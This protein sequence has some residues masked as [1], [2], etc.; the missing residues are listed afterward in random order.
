MLRLITAASAI[1][2][3]AP[4]IAQDASPSADEVQPEV[5]APAEAPE[6]APAPATPSREEAVKQLVESEFA[7]YDEDQSGELSKEEFAKWVSALRSK[8][9]TSQGR[10][11]VPENEMAE[12]AKNAFA[13]ADADKSEKIS[14]VEL[15]T[16]L[17]G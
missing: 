11:P 7:A 9:L 17:T 2:L 4:A 15:E 8:S 3:S 5:S 14:K 12:W 1:A 10:P 16:F 6:A 13:K